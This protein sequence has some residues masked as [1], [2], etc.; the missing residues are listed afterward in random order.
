[1]DKSG[2]NKAAMDGIN[3]NRDVPIEVR[4]VVVIEQIPA[5]AKFDKE[6]REQL[7]DIFRDAADYS[8]ER[9]LPFRCFYTFAVARKPA[10]APPGQ[11]SLSKPILMKGDE[12]MA[13]DKL[14]DVSPLALRMSS[15][16]N[17][18]Y[19]RVEA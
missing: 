15:P 13:T 8:A 12:P 10:P 16:F 9:K 3:Q 17:A 14:Y 6:A 2:A 11:K 4:F 18:H 7:L 5:H 1:M 19:W